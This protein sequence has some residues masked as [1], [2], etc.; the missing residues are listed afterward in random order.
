M[1]KG[2]NALKQNC[3][4]LQNTKICRKTVLVMNFVLCGWAGMAYQCTLYNDVLQASPAKVCTRCNLMIM[5]GLGYSHRI[6]S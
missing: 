4:L 2:S 3:E 5:W 1:G 6:N